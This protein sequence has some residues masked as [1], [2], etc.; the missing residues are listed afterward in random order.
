MKHFLTFLLTFILTLP[1]SA[2]TTV[3]QHE[4]WGPAVAL[5]L[6]TTFENFEFHMMHQEAMCTYIKTSLNNKYI[7]KDKDVTV[8]INKTNNV[9]NQIK[10]L[11]KT[12]KL[13]T[14]AIKEL[15]KNKEM[16]A[17]AI[18][19]EQM[20]LLENLDSVYKELHDIYQNNKHI[21]DL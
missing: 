12:Y 1:L 7:T 14:K 8:Y 2:Q 10:I 9:M 11:K 13:K 15:S 19:L 6:P 18:K 17:G 3:E 16:N 20:T 5:Y 4:H 21:L